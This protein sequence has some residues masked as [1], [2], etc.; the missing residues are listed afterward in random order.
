M[1]RLQGTRDVKAAQTKKTLPGDTV[2][3]VPAAGRGTKIGLGPKAF[4]L[5]RG[6]SILSKVVRILAT[7]VTRTLVGVPYD[8][9]ERA[10]DELRGLA[11]V[12]SGGAS[13]QETVFTLLNHSTEQ[14]VVIH[15]VVRPFA[16]QP[17]IGAVI[18]AGKQYGA[19]VPCI[20]VHVPVATIEDG[21]ITG[22]IP[23]ARLWLTQS[24]QAYH[25]DILGQAYTR[26]RGSGFEA[27]TTWELV[28]HAGIPVRA[29]AGEERN[30]KI[31]TLFDWEMATKMLEPR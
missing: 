27:Q 14:I 18:D 5:L 22:S 15:D 4:L 7:C 11:E 28:V 17:L 3:L 2:A 25:R 23:R 1:Y 6:E 30:I 8:Y 31:T 24:P 10:R 29:V 16:S 21:L 20:E 9:L 12:F 26:A 13:R 19:A